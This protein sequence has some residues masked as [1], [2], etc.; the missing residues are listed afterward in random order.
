MK[1]SFFIPS[2]ILPTILRYKQRDNLLL[3][4]VTIPW[5]PFIVFEESIENLEYEWR[6]SCS[7]A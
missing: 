3:F 4:V 1:Q 6:T 7:I 2:A 5:S